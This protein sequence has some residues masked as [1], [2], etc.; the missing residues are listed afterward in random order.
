M[1]RYNQVNIESA[2]NEGF[3]IE[4]LVFAVPVTQKIQG[5]I[6][7]SGLDLLVEFFK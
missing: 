2:I 1:L 6:S 3:Q 7:A 5:S 4:S